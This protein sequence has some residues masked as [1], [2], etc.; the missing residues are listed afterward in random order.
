MKLK[1]SESRKVMIREVPEK[2][3]G[4]CAAMHD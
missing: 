2:L 4:R 1:V 3:V